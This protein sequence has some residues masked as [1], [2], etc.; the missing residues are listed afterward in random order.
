MKILAQLSIRA[1]L[2]LSLGFS[3]S[4][5]LIIGIL[6]L[7][8]ARKADLSINELQLEMGHSLHIAQ[9]LNQ[10]GKSRI[11]L[12][13][14]LQHDPANEL[15]TLHKHPVSLHTD[16]AEAYDRNAKEAWQVSIE[17]DMLPDE[18][19][20]ANAFQKAHTTLSKEG[21]KPAIAAL[22][23]GDYATATRILTNDEKV[24]KPFH[25]A[26]EVAETMLSHHEEDAKHALSITTE[27][28]KS[29][30]SWFIGLILTGILV[31][32]LLSFVTI[33]S[34]TRSIKSLGQATSALAQGDLRS[35]IESGS[36]DEL[37]YVTQE[38]NRVAKMFHGIV[39]DVQS[40]A[41]Q[42][43]S[44][45]EETSTVTQ[46]ASE[47]VNRQR[48]ETQQIA[49][50]MTQMNTTVQ[51]V[52]HNAVSAADAA[53]NAEASSN[54]GRQIV[55]RTVNS[56]NQIAEEVD[57]T[58]SV[59]Q[60]LEKDSTEIGTVLDVIRGIAEQTNLLA[61]NAAIEAARAGEQGRGFAVVADEVRTLASRTQESTEE[62]QNMITRLQ[63]GTSEA[64]KVM[65]AGRNQASIG[66][67][68][69]AE[70][71][72]ALEAITTA[73]DQITAMNNQI[74]RD[75]EEQKTVAEEISRNISSIARVAEETATGSNQTYSASRQLAELAVNLQ[76]R[77]SQLR[78]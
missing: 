41:A 5:M 46:Q 69:A 51:N 13:L 23:A 61:L 26:V 60:N 77:I 76:S 9:S 66:V 40:A 44:A 68:Q 21:Y 2:L 4:V 16:K 70:A 27:R 50:A 55:Q 32:G 34:I 71:G 12:L 6:G 37:A 7:S 54:Q 47:G 38:F 65:E 18:I 14:A 31:G 15:S 33:G 74:R 35:R 48:M 24:G 78:V 73:V 49:T 1:R 25:T 75:S 19:A 52:A 42:I 58:A 36:K 63:S 10:L 57:R 39:K 72:A 53:K 20:S 67:K 29:I 11:E 56:I 30:F 45:A 17:Q 59:I 3:I 22:I 28:Y 8:N 64:V 62:I 43:S